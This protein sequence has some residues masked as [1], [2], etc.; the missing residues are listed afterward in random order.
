MLFRITPEVW[1]AIELRVYRG[2]RADQE[3]QA[4]RQAEESSGQELES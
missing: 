3:H 2:K 4:K 1:R